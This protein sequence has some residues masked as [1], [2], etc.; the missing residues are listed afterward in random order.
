MTVSKRVAEKKVA[1]FEKNISRRGG[2]SNKTALEP[3]HI[4][5]I[6]FVV[7]AVASFIFQVVRMAMNGGNPEQEYS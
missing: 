4:A 1:K 6:L 2:A 3:S 5:L 7:L